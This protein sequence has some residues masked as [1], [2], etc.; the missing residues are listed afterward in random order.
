MTKEF[1]GLELTIDGGGAA[2]GDTPEEAMDE[3]V[4]IITDKVL[5]FLRGH[6][7]LPTADCNGRIGMVFPDINGNSTGMIEVVYNR[8]EEA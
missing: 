7:C 6:G 3:V 1:R 2:F 5:P 8:E 4:R